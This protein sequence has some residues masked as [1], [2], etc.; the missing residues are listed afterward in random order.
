MSEALTY[1]PSQTVNSVWVFAL[2][3]ARDEIGTWQAPQP[4]TAN[5]KPAQW[6]LRDALGITSLDPDGVEIFTIE[7]ISD[8]GLARY[9]TEASGYDESAVAQDKARLD[10]LAGPV[11]LLHSRALD[12]VDQ[13][14]KPTDPL[15]FV[16]RYDTRVNVIVPQPIKTESAKGHLSGQNASDDGSRMPAWP[17]LLMIAIVAG[18]VAVLVVPKL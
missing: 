4:G 16:G 1:A 8:Y 11:L 13:I 10:A 15:V 2:N 14:L 9:L 5:G 7:D 12:K 3:I 6:P 17:F 18:L